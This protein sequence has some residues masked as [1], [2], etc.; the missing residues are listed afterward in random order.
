MADRK[1]LPPTLRHYGYIPC[2]LDYKLP[3]P[4]ENQPLIDEHKVSYEMMW[5][6]GLRDEG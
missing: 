3:E 5:D 6:V 1:N 2:R 4:N